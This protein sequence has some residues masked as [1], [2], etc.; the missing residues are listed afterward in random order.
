VQPL[1]IFPLELV[2]EDDALD[3][4]AALLEPLAFTKK[5]L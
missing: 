1:L 3:A 5:A 4:R 2:V